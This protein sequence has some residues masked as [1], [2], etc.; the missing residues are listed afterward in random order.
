M[1]HIY[2]LALV[3]RRR[4]FSLQCPQASTRMDWSCLLGLKNITQSKITCPKKPAVLSINYNDQNDIIEIHSFEKYF[5]YIFFLTDKF[6]VFGEYMND[7]IFWRLTWK[8]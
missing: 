1:S 6:P 5:V 7:A 4:T 8:V 3:L 2:L